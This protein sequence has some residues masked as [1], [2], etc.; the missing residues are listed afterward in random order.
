MFTNGQFQSNSF[1]DEEAEGWTGVDKSRKKELLQVSMD[2]ATDLSDLA[3][4][5]DFSVGN[6]FSLSSRPTL[7]EL[8]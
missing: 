3:E 5:T 8:C 4:L 2:A 7:Q 6:M 1:P